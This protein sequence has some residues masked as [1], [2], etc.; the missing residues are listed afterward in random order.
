MKFQKKIILAY[1]GISI[2][3]AVVMGGTA[4]IFNV[5]RYKENEY[6]SI[7]MVSN[8]KMQQMES[9]LSEMESVIKYFLSDV[10]ILDA[11]QDF[12]QLDDAEY[13]ELYYDQ[14]ASTIRQK[15]T[16]YYLIDEFYRVLVFNKK[17]NVICNTNYADKMV[18]EEAS[19]DT[20]PWTEQVSNQGGRNE[21]LGL[22]KDDWG[23]KKRPLVLSVVKEI[24]GMDMGYVEV[25]MEK[26]VLDAE[27]S[28]LDENI[29]YIF[30]D[31]E[32]NVIYARDEKFN[33][34]NY[35]SQ[36]EKKE[37]NIGTIEKS[38]GKTALCL[39]ME[40]KTSDLVLLTV[41]G[42]DINGQAMMS[43]LPLSLIL[44][45]G[46]LVFS[47]SYVWLASKRLTRPIRQL[48]RV[49]ET[50][51]LDRLDNIEA[52][53]PRKISNDEIEA[54]YVSYRDV[55]DRLRESMIQEKRMSL[56]QL[57]AQFDLLQAQVNPHFIY[58]VLNVISG[59][60]MMSGDE[61]ICEIC[62]ELAQMLR[63]ATNTKEKYAT[64]S[65]EVK[66]LELYL[67]LLK[68]RYE[69]KLSY[70]ISIADE[71]RDK[72]LPK[73]VLQQ[74]VENAIVHGYG[75]IPDVIEIE[76][77]GLQEE[78]KWYIR[79]H[80]SGSGILPETLGK[81]Q[82]SITSI[83]SKL[84]KDRRNVELEIGG[85]GLVNTYSRLYLLY[86]EDLI[87]DI[88]SK[89][90]EGTDVIIGAREGHTDVQDTGSR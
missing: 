1:V 72:I 40:S 81:I 2:F 74:I 51:H 69:Y 43:S 36:M 19:L 9:V 60:G 89:A 71:I 87:F 20:Y 88:H 57:Q 68:Y 4:Y 17:G 47:V 29:Q 7:R 54:L 73:I 77:S 90:H 58:N 41:T 80:D 8:A 65:D 45:F 85:M 22:H 31:R 64:V 30:M 26:S 82:D 70:K 50:T 42:V 11:L 24:Q 76:L 39:K 10:D 23:E 13:E 83:R 14:A 59:R 34:E 33:P 66:Y 28:G 12:A 25:Q 84:T 48:Q 52:E 55:L 56:L 75:G 35:L 86:N 15:L 79:V 67:S 49:M 16:N 62:G 37:E 44:L 5:K 46:S 61:G 38:D 63:Y 18:D 78:Q 53:I 3:M 32:G 6:A 21:V 27:I